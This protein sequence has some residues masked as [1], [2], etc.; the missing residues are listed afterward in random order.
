MT[1][2]TKKQTLLANAI[3]ATAV[4]ERSN[5]GMHSALKEMV[6]YAKQDD[7]K[8]ID[9]LSS[10]LLSRHDFSKGPKKWELI[11]NSVV[12]WFVQVCLLDVNT[13]TG[14][15]SPRADEEYGRAWNKEVRTNPWYKIARELQDFKAPDLEKAFDAFARQMARTGELGVHVDYE[16]IAAKLQTK[17]NNVK[18]TK[19]HKNW[20]ADARKV[21]KEKGLDDLS[22]LIAPPPAATETNVTEP[23][24]VTH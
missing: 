21:A 23:V 24:E 14:N 16:G 9:I 18:A 15:V 17:V 3:E 22:G 6:L 19:S 11:T 2:Q 20:L 12:Q 1:Q 10:Y 8:N 5:E 7:W 13:T 4:V